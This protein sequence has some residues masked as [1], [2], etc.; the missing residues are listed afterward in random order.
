MFY[1]ARWYDSYL[2]RFIQPD[3][4]VPD[5]KNPVAWDRY[6]YSANNPVRYNDPSGHCWGAFSWVRSLPSYGT[7]CNNL[8]MA[9]VIVTSPDTTVG[10]KV[11]A[12]AYIVGEGTAHAAAAVG[13][14]GVACGTVA[15][16]AAAAET[17][18]GIG[19]AACADGDCTNEVAA[20]TQVDLPAIERF[21]QE[22]AQFNIDRGYGSGFGSFWTNLAKQ[23]LESGNSASM[24]I[25]RVGEKITGMMYTSTAGGYYEI[26][27]LEGM[28]GGAGTTLFRQAIQDSVA[29]GYGGSIYLF[30]AQKAVEWYLANFPGAQM[31]ADGRLYWSAEAA[32]ALL[33]GK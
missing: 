4:I 14:A 5:P 15:P 32:Q 23:L 6:A 7:T 8:D 21:A 17:A 31:L 24:F 2:N 9:L 19:T 26:K 20:L 30:P 33:N 28:G 18:L 11:A 12:S 3:S 1:N 27:L 13:A 29:K 22:A 10:Q 16:C 25:N